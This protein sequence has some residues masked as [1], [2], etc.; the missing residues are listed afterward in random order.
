M[1]VEFV[2]VALAQFVHSQIDEKP[3]LV[4]PG[5]FHLMLFQIYR[6]TAV[7]GLVGVCVALKRVALRRDG[8]ADIEHLREAKVKP[9]PGYGHAL[10]LKWNLAGPLQTLQAIAFCTERIPAAITLPDVH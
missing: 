1:S 6:L 7:A 4:Q 10:H 8:R 3:E 9:I 2:N 5:K